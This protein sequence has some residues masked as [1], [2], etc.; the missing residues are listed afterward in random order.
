MSGHNNHNNHTLETGLIATILQ[1]GGDTDPEGSLERMIRVP[2]YPG[3]RAG[4][5]KTLGGMGR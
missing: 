1:S 5:M 3:D 2:G 4:L